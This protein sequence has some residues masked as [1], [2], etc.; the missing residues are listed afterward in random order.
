MLFII[1]ENYIFGKFDTFCKR[2]EKISDM[3]NI[4]ES[5]LELQR[6]KIEGIEEIN[7]HFQTIAT[8]TKSKKYDVLDHRKKEVHA[9][10]L[11]QGSD[12]QTLNPV[13]FVEVMQGRSIFIT[14]N[15]AFCCSKD[16]FSLV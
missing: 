4:M 10:N 8:N 14:M 6:V 12:N 16:I 9:L 7:A 1:S 5:L 15:I 11:S 2:L 13:P 3:S